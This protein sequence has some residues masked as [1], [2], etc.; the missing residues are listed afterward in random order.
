MVELAWHITSDYSE[1]EEPGAQ[2]HI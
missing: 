1:L 2:W